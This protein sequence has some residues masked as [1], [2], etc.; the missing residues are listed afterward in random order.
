MRAKWRVYAVACPTWREV[1]MCFG[2]GGVADIQNAASFLGSTSVRVG[3]KALRDGVLVML[4]VFGWQAAVAFRLQWPRK[5]A[6]SGVV[7]T[8]GCRKVA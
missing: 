4:L 6:V 2:H 7:A 1:G 8:C 5:I 3:L